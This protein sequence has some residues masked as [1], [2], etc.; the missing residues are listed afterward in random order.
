MF[1][2]FRLPTL[3]R[4]ELSVRKV[5]VPF[6]HQHVNIWPYFRSGNTEAATFHRGGGLWMY[7]SQH[8]SLKRPVLEDS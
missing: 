5:A 8:L 1:L 2:Q 7:S 3:L 6:I 4:I